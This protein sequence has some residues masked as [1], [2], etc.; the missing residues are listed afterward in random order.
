MTQGK[1]LIIDGNNLLH[2]VYWTAGNLQNSTQTK[3]IF[4]YLNTT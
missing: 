1:V 3:H 4:L 2:S